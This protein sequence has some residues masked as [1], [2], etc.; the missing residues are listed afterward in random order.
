MHKLTV[1]R[2]QHPIGQGGFHSVHLHTDG[3]RFS[4]IFDCGGGTAGHR[5]QL[6][7][8]MVSSA[9][10]EYDWL[11]ISHLDADHINGLRQLEK[12]GIT[13]SNVFLPHVDL[14]QSMFLMLLKA[15][16]TEGRVSGESLDTLLIAAQLH[17]GVFGRARI[18]VSGDQEGGEPPDEEGVVQD[19]ANVDRPASALLESATRKSLDRQRAA[20]RFPDGTSVYL[21]DADWKF[22]FYSREWAFPDPIKKVWD[23]PVLT[24]LRQAM[25]QLFV[26][27]TNTEKNFTA[28]IKAALHETVTALVAN[29]ILSG[30]SPKHARISRRITVNSLLKLLYKTLP[31]LHDYNGA[32]LCMYSGPANVPSKC[33]RQYYVRQHNLATVDQARAGLTRTVGWMGMGDA[34]LKDDKELE[35]FAHHFRTQL[36]LVS[37]LMLPHHG[38][39]HNYGKNLTQLHGLLSALPVSPVPVLVV[40]SDPNHEKYSHPH[41]DVQ[42]ACKRFGLLHNVNLRWESVFEE[43]I[44]SLELPILLLIR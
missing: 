12:Y 10:V 29:K 32:S 31:D 17:A 42:H 1:E 23:L 27:G 22:R 14:P 28:A 37:T 15:L 44:S 26:S 33:A 35:A 3:E 5:D 43:S 4:V 19:D 11:V 7:K 18:V 21:Q 40:A 8:D 13:F 34:N 38:S 30:F 16:A 24:T 2:T 20:S 9:V 25:S 41:E 36:P 39:R 6:V